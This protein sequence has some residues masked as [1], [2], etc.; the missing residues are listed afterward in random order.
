[1]VA[2][3]FRNANFRFFLQIHKKFLIFLQNKCLLFC[4]FFTL[5]PHSMPKNQ[6]SLL[7]C[8]FN[9]TFEEKK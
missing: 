5:R 3:N 8:A 2:H 6:D 4:T 7:F 1:M 9:R